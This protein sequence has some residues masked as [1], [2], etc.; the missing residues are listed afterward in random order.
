M[1][2]VTGTVRSAVKQ[3]AQINIWQQKKESGNVLS[4]QEL[5]KRDGWGQSDWMKHNY[6]QQL[7]DQRESARSQ[8]LAN[9][10]ANGKRLTPDEIRELQQENPD[11]YRRYQ[12][13]LKAEERFKER[14][15]RCKT[16]D[17]V[18]QV[19]FESVS[20]CLSKMKSVEHNPCIGISEKLAT[21]Q[22][23]LGKLRLVSEAE[24]KFKQSLAYQALPTKESVESD[25]FEENEVESDDSK[26]SVGEVVESENETEIIHRD[27][28]RE[29]ESI[30]Q[31][32]EEGCGRIEFR[33]RIELEP[34]KNVFENRKD[35]KVDITV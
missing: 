2:M 28:N 7:L 29:I 11:L 27:I 6:E 16:K 13:N 18:E 35:R 5:N 24:V 34:Q 33:A 22:E 32:L 12:E 21:A 14:L 3:Q 4:K 25:N 8:E 15:E 31:E 9:K 17:E 30:T 20:E 10:V 19:K 23:V 26:E 1:I